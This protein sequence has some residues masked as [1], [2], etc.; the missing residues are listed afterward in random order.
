MTKKEIL[1]MKYLIELTK[2]KIESVKGVKATFEESQMSKET[3]IEAMEKT[4]EPF[5]EWVE[6]E[7]RR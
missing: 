1:Y 6:A 2:E 7:E 3:I 5:E 4:I